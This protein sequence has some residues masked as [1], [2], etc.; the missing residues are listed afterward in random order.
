MS[1]FDARLAHI[2]DLAS[3]GLFEH[4]EVPLVDLGAAREAATNLRSCGIIGFSGDDMRGTLLLGASAGALP[5]DGDTAHRDWL[6]ELTNQLLGRIKNQLL[7]YGITIYSSTPLVLRGDHLAPMGDG[8]PPHL[9]AT[10][11]GVIAVWLDA[12]ARPDLAFAEVADTSA[13][14]MEGEAMMF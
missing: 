14:V 12:E 5:G 7:T 8:P 10:A 13:T 9:Y 4:Y 11:D 1:S 2:I 6:A 3:R